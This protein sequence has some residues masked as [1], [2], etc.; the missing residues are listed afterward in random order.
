MTHMWAD[1]AIFYHIYPLGLCGAPDT[2]IFNHAVVHRLDKLHDWLD[3][4]QALGANAI[5]LG[6]LFQSSSHGYDTADYYQVDRRLGNNDTLARFTDAV[7]QRGM[8]LVLDAVF[9]HVGRDFWAFKDVQ[10]HGK[11]SAYRE[12]FHKL[13][14]N[15]CSPKGDPFN[16]EGWQG[17][18]SL[19]K[20]NL[21]H[22]HVRAHLF[23]A[24]GMWMDRFDIDGLRL[25]A[26]DCIDLV[27]LQALRDF[28][29]AK[30]LD[31][32][33]LGE[34]VHGDYRHWVNTSTL[35]SVTNYACYKGLYSSLVDRNYYEIAY[36]LERQFGPNGIYRDLVLYNFVDNHDVDR[37][38]SKFTDQA[39][40]YPLYLLLFTMP[41]IPSIYYGS[42][43][44]LYAKKGPW[45]D[46]PLR[47]ELI[48][49]QMSDQTPQP[50]LVD[51][52]RRLATFRKRS[53][54]LRLGN[55]LPIHV[56]HQQ[57]A[58]LRQFEREK[59]LIVLNSSAQNVEV[60]LPLQNQ[61]DVAID[62]LNGNERFYF[63]NGSL[64]LKL[65]P[66]WGRVLKFS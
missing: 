23:D 55:Y 54:T 22:P 15:E 34:V 17:H 14:F 9:N 16:Y 27:F 28:T 47:P 65:P 63:E 42:E 32:W 44:G 24:V 50:H 41:G 60:K 56:A 33:L 13:R 3:H 10:K 37:V 51:C 36:N 7:H 21:D 8:H 46:K 43:W 20:L 19:V 1:N 4:I 53:Q 49:N 45:S 18:Y 48:L 11:N 5:Y 35:D 31:F 40:L 58:F 30:R 62:A 12:W 57:F 29:K 6:P 61:S 26:A 2:N 52:I 59:L 39:L 64:R 38:A 25:D 66:H